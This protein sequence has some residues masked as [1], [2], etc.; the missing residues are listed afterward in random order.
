M[1]LLAVLTL[2]RK[3]SEWERIAVRMRMRK[4]MRK[5]VLESDSMR[6]NLMDEW[7]EKWWEWEA[8]NTSNT[9]N[10]N[11]RARIN[12]RWTQH[13]AD[14]REGSSHQVIPTCVHHSFSFLTFLTFLLIN[15]RYRICCEKW[16]EMDRE[17]ENDERNRNEHKERSK[18]SDWETIWNY[19]EQRKYGCICKIKVEADVR[20]E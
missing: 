16:W 9:S 14:S 8:S 7:R 19:C 11:E 6:S 12:A 3:A 20:S 1:A 15:A 5:K 17:K 18:S 2:S 4:R 13:T 10:T